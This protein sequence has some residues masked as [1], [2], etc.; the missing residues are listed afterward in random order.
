VFKKLGLAGQFEISKTRDVANSIPSSIHWLSSYTA[1]KMQR[2]GISELQIT[3]IL[4]ESS[5][6]S[7]LDLIVTVVAHL[8]THT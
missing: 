3:H 5:I 2:K 1:T 7:V 4:S 6:S 8:D